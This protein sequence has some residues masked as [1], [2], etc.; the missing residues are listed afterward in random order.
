MIAVR[1]ILDS[2]LLGSLPISLPDSFTNRLVEVVVLP[3]EE[4]S[5]LGKL[6]IDSVVGILQQYR[7]PNLVPFEKEAWK[8]AVVDKHDA[9]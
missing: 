3:V 6:D 4:N 9:D 2:S 7:N 1:Q 8:M 5:E